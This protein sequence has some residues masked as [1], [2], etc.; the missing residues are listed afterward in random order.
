LGWTDPFSSA[1]YSERQSEYA[2]HLS[3]SAGYGVYTPQMIIDGASEAVGSDDSDVSRKIAQAAARQKAAINLAAL[4]SQTS[5]LQLQINVEVPPEIAV[6]EPSDIVIAVTED[7]L[8]SAVLRG[9]NG[10]RHLQHTAVVRLLQTAAVLK[11]QAREW[12]GTTSITVMPE[13]KPADLK[14]IAFVQE[15]RSRRI[16]GVGWMAQPLDGASRRDAPSL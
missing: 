16:V 1:A 13:W 6:T 11:A 8:S 7:N 9:E 14:V 2:G 12:S 15:Q 5:S 4:P 10:G 3:S